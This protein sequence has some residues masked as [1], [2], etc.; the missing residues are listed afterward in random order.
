MEVVHRVRVNQHRQ[1]E[2]LHKATCQGYNTLILPEF[3]G[4]GQEDP[5]QHLFICET[6]WAATNVHDEAVKIM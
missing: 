4:V 1:E 3:Q 2:G 6:I 5:K